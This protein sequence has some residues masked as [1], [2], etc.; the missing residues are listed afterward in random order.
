[1]GNLKLLKTIILQGK[2]MKIWDDFRTARIFRIIRAVR[3]SSQIF[4]IFLVEW[5]FW[6]IFPVR[7][8]FWKSS[9][10]KC[11]FIEKTSNKFKFIDNLQQAQF[12]RKVVLPFLLG[13]QQ[14]LEVFRTHVSNESFPGFHKS[15]ISPQ[16]CRR[17]TKW[18]LAPW[19]LFASFFVGL[20]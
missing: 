16:K 13:Y 2:V 7:N 20:F 4:M 17:D 19:N 10:N 15:E 8:N 5:S 18:L 1:M 6:A 14:F 12:H 11:K 3:E 9:K